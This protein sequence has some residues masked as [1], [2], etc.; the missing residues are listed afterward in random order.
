[1]TTT[2]LPRGIIC[3]NDNCNLVKYARAELCNLHLQMP[4]HADLNQPLDSTCYVLA[5]RTKLR[6]SD[7][8]LEAEMVQQHLSFSVDQQC[9]A[10]DVNC[11]QQQAIRADTKRSKLSQAFK[12]QC[13]PGGFVEVNLKTKA[14]M[15]RNQSSE[16][17]LSISSSETDLPVE[18]CFPQPT[19]DP[20]RP[21][22]GF[23]RGMVNP[24]S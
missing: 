24:V 12:W 6:C 17:L 5:I 15:F 21:I 8:S 3:D 16:R 19:A 14:G 23:R 7:W 1:M 22:S 9:F 20:S 11:E 13:R 2:S 4:G 18:L 10:L